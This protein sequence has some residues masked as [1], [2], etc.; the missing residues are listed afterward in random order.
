MAN[1]ETLLSSFSGART[2]LGQVAMSGHR[3]LSRRRKRQ[4]VAEQS[5]AGGELQPAD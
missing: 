1:A 5:P 3:W 4:D 2:L